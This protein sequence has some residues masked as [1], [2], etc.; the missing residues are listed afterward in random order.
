MADGVFN[1]AKGRVVEYYNR[2]K[3]NDPAASTFN[4]SL[5]T[6]TVTDAVMKD[7]DNFAAITAGALAEATFTNYAR[8]TVDDTALAALPAPDD[9]NDWYAVAFPNQTWTA[10]GGTTDNT[11]SRMVIC[12]DPLGTDVTTNF[13]PLCYYDFSV[14]TDGTN[15]TVQFAATGF[16]KAA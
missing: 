6:G 3:N 16:F 7:Y 15:L 13:I 11:L 1:I 2:V 12:Y 10:A 14:T 9:A 4:L 8:K 5:F